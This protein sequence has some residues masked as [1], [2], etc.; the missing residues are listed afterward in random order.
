MEEGA[1]SPQSPA[2]GDGSPGDPLCSPVERQWLREARG[3]VR[4]AL[5][6]GGPSEEREANSSSAAAAAA[7][8]AAATT[9]TWRHLSRALRRCRGTQELPLGYRLVSLLELQ[10]QQHHPCC[11][12]LTWSSEEFQKSACESKSL[13]PDQRILQ[14]AHLILVGYLTERK[15][16]RL[17]DGSL[18]IRDNTGT[19]PC[20]LL[21]FKLEWLENLLLF[22]SW[23]YIPPKGQNRDGYLEILA[24]PIQ[25]MP[26]PEKRIDIPPVLDPEQAAKLLSA[27][28]QCKKVA[29]LNVAGELCRLSTV[30]SIHHKVFFFLFLKCSHSEACVPIL[31]QSPQLAWHRVLQLG[32]SY[33][34]TAL[35]ISCLKASGLRVFVPSSSSHLLTYCMEHVTE[36]YLDSTPEGSS[37]LPASPVVCTPPNSSL[38]VGERDK[39]LVPVRR[40][41]VVSYAGTITQILNV[42]AGLYELDNRFTLCLAYQQQLNSG[43]GLRP[44]ACVE[45]RDVHLLQKPLAAFPFVLGACL[46]TTL[47]LK[48]FSK[49]S[50]LHQPA[51]SC[52]NLYIQLLLRYNLTLPLYL[53]L[54]SLL[55]MLEKRFCCFVQRQ[56][57]FL[58]SSHSTAGA[59]EKFIVPILNSLVPSKKQVRDIHWEILAEK[60]HCPLEQYQIL[61]PPCQIPPFSLLFT[62]A[63]K[64]CLES[65]SPLHQMSSAPEIQHIGAQELNRRLAWSYSVLSAESFQPPI[66]LLGI[67]RASSRSGFLQLR[68]STKALSCIIFH[69]D[70]RPF[71]D[72]SLLGYL[73]QI[74]RFQLVMEQFLQSD[75]PSWQELKTQEYIKEKKSRL[76]AQFFVEDVKILHSEKR[77]PE[78][79][80][81]RE[82]SCSVVKDNGSS[83]A[84]PR[85]PEGNLTNI[86]RA[87]AASNT[88]EPPKSSAADGRCVCRLFLATQKE[89][90][91][92]RNYPQASEGRSKG[93]QEPQLCFQVTVLWMDKPEQ[94]K[95]VGEAMVQKELS[96]FALGEASKAQPEI[97]LLFLGKSLRWFPFLHPGGLYQ[98]II[99]QC[100]E[101]DVFDKLCLPM[102]SGN[103]SMMKS[104]SLF[105]PVPDAGYLHYVSW[106]SQLVSEASEMEEKLFSI[107]EILS[108]SFT[109]SLVS[110]SG[111]IAERTLCESLTGK[112]PVAACSAKQ[113]KGNR[114][115]WDY[116]VKLSILPA[117]GSSAGLDVYV[118][119]TF[120]PYLSG[121]L[122]GAKILFH[123]MQRKISRLKNVYCTYMASSCLR[124]LSPPP[125][126]S[127]SRPFDGTSNLS[128][129]YLSHILLQPHSLC[130]VQVTCHLTCVLT[131]SLRWS[132]SLCDSILKEGTCIQLNPP[133]LSHTG[134]IKASARILVE[135]GTGEAVVLC[136]NHQ[137]R[138]VLCLSPKDWDV[139]QKHV[140]RKG[141]V[142]IQHNDGSIG[143]RCMEPPDDLLTLYL[144]S[145][146]R[147]P[148][149]C[150]S[151]VL[152]A[153]LD[154]KPPEAGPRQI[155]RFFSHETEFLSQM[156]NQLN[157]ICLSIQTAT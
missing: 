36:Q 86:E 101:L 2:E 152:A 87:E 108:P 67:L 42:Q 14:R 127:S 5:L 134:V 107:T 88:P 93:G 106:I 28:A 137:V 82:E 58:C 92:W 144:R 17:T 3:F 112:K 11:S 72:V 105:L 119:A 59:A 151:L 51:T 25:V 95:N 113:L 99:P 70:G 153:R 68:D 154:R 90:L 43:R 128:A 143:P 27:R 91:M 136:R 29:E 142:S 34:L 104:Q 139:V 141:C 81:A 21:H 71:A 10:S 131:L 30:L 60:H 98:L 97:L 13:F 50:I 32:H 138:D 150:R 121:M 56:Q 18:Y 149:V 157:L 64:R 140:W 120:L 66:M 148:I 23:T 146:C 96:A 62:M 33:V 85:S 111:V 155:R 12:H 65:F 46:R 94:C 118:E 49:C 61:N 103:L 129:V 8:A 19:L 110:F 122:P 37:V 76:Y 7:A 74:E 115:P 135:D 125:P 35:K 45:L 47:V 123:N 73:L 133:C 9:T 52:G 6:R 26:G 117:C 53:C 16:D 48:S 80:K 69:R 20:E 124:V 41:K 40:S 57:L 1:S 24:D 78:V 109:R 145:L 89:G 75:F 130:Q 4:Q 54:V 55:E 44:G 116:S 83:T 126:D 84:E 63:E 100:S 102:G 39:I 114:L 77:A 15:E 31:V 22:P 38:E 156:R 79:P 147:S 132:C